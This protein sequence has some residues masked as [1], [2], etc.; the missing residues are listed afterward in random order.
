MKRAVSAFPVVPGVM[1]DNEASSN[2]TVVEVRAPD[3]MGVLYRITNAIAEMGLDIRHAKVQTL[4]HEVVDAFYV[5]DG[6]KHKVT[7][8]F[9]LK[10]LERAILFGLEAR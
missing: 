5:R 1:I 9:H 10:E 7:D 3:V 4:G 6:D 8:P 2:A